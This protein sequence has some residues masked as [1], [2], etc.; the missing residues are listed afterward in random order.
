[1]KRPDVEC[2]C[3]FIHTMDEPKSMSCE[4]AT[5]Q[6]RKDWIIFREIRTLKSLSPRTGAESRRLLEL[7]QESERRRKLPL[8]SNVKVQ[9]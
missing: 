2:V 8:I 5:L 6:T 7:L 1:M 9:S 3:G 4:P